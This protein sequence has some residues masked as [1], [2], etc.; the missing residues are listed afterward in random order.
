MLTKGEE[1]LSHH[2]EIYK[3]DVS[4]NNLIINFSC[5]LIELDSEEKH[6]LNAI[7]KYQ[8][9][10]H[11]KH[12]CDSKICILKNGIELVFYENKLFAIGSA[13]TL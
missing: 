6:V 1:I 5:G 4:V 13:N 3:N 12:I 7:K 2:F 8:E 11:M 9:I 10:I